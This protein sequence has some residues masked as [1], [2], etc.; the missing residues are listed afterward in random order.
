MEYKKKYFKYKKKYQNLKNE[1]SIVG[2]STSSQLKNTIKIDGI[3]FELLYRGKIDKNSEYNLVKIKSTNDSKSSEFICYNSNSE[4]GLWRLGVK[5]KDSSNRSWCKSDFEVGKFEDTLSKDG[6]YVS[7]TLIHMNL[8]KFIQENWDKLEIKQFGDSVLLSKKSPIV[9]YICGTDT[10][11]PERIK[12]IERFDDMFISDLFMLFDN[13]S[14]R[15]GKYSL[16]GHYSSEVNKSFNKYYSKKRVNNYVESEKKIKKCGSCYMNKYKD[17]YNDK[18]NYCSE[19]L[20]IFSERFNQIIKPILHKFILDFNLNLEE[21]DTFDLQ[22]MVSFFKEKKVTD[23]KHEH[24]LK[25][26]FYILMI[27]YQFLNKYYKILSREIERKYITNIG[28]LKIKVI[29]YKCQIKHKKKDENLTYFYMAYKVIDCNG[30]VS[31]LE[32]YITNTLCADKIFYNPI[33]IIKNDNKINMYGLYEKYSKGCLYF[34][35]SLDYAFQIISPAPE[36]LNQGRLDSP[37]PYYN[38]NFSD[39]IPKRYLFVGEMY[40]PTTFRSIETND[41]EFQLSEFLEINISDIEIERSE[42]VK[43]NPIIDSIIQ[44]GDI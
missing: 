42:I 44:E 24:Q 12:E 6:D 3:N 7:S 17:Y 10:I 20:L 9:K 26:Y 38:F 37:V 15:C 25:P 31:M 34:C 32:P 21:Y 8:Q 2:G 11:S 4:L 39:G 28:L 41:S 27:A 33:C 13:I 5:N 36:L 29:V 16:I 35:K 1:L 30:T 18:K 23:Y 43:D 40:I 22:K 19:C 14:I